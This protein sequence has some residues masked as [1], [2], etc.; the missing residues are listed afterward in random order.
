[1][2]KVILP[3]TLVDVDEIVKPLFFIAGPVWGG[4]DWQ[5]E[6]F[7]LLARKI[8][9]FT[10]AIPIRYKADHPLQNFRL[11]GN[12]SAF[13]RQLNWERY[14]LKMAAEDKDA[15]VV[16]WF[17]KESASNPR[18][19]E[20]GPYG[21]DSYGEVAEWRGRMMDNPGFKVVVG[22]DPSFPGLDTI[23]RNFCLALKIDFPIF[24]T[25]E[26]TLDAA[27]KRMSI[28]PPPR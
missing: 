18:P 9:K 3:T 8:P 19:R 23:R 24:P 25:L 12:E 21:Q 20:N 10:A 27:I 4:D 13:P 28:P 7:K 6:A 2:Q 26:A 5:H 15:C 1:M 14:Y 22:G 17:A 11:A 16:F